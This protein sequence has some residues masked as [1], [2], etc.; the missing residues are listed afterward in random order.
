MVSYA[1]Y[2]T[3]LTSMETETWAQRRAEVRVQKKKKKKHL[4]N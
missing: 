4:R 3:G 1:T 2:G